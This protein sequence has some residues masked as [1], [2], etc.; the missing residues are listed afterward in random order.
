MN[1]K[2]RV[3]KVDDTSSEIATIGTSA[4]VGEQI[5]Q[6][7]NLMQRHSV[8]DANYD[9]DY[10]EFPDN[11]I[12]VISD[13]DSI[14]EVELVN[15]HIRFGNTK[16][17]ALVDSGSTCTI[18]NRNLANA[19]VLNSPYKTFGYSLRIISTLKLSPMN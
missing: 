9:P 10:D 5:S 16:T 12:A 15:M 17:K 11:C 7:E 4:P 2:P 19:V 14:R 3:S 18:I 1:P 13:S 6:I 8:Y